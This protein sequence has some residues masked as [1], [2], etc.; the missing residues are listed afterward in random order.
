MS[1]KPA[2]ILIVEDDAG[3]AV[4]QRRRLERAG[5]QVDTVADVDAAMA[6]LSAADTSV[7]IIDYRLGDTTGLDLQRRMK[8]AQIEV[9]VILVSGAMDDAAIVEALRAGVRDV[10]VKTADYLDYLPDAVRGVLNQAATGRIMPTHTPATCILIVED[11]PG[12]ATLERKQLERAGYS[13]AVAANATEAMAAVRGGG[14][15][16]AILDQRLPDNISGLELYERWKAEGIAVP[17]ILV[18]GFADQATAIQAIR[19]GIRD[20]VPKSAEFLDYLGR[21]VD[22]VVTQERT[23]RKLAESE[24][25]LASIIGTAMDVIVMC[26]ADGKIVLFNR[27][28]QE[29]FGCSPSD[30]LGR[31]ITGFI[32]GLDLAHHLRGR[33]ELLATRQ[34]SQDP[35]AIEVSVTDIVIHD[36]SLF[37]VIPRDITER[38]NA[39][40]QLR[41]AA[42]RKDEFLGMLAHE[43]RNPLAAIMTA[44]EVLHRTQP[45]EGMAQQ[46]TGVVRR[47]SRALSRMVDDLLDVSR[48]TLGKIQLTSEPLILGEVVARAAESVRDA[49]A[50]GG[51]EVELR[52]SPEPVWLDADA[53]RLEQVVTNLLTN[54]I[55]FTPR[56]GTVTLVVAVEGADAV[57]KVSDTG[58]G[59]PADLLPRVFDLFVQG[60]ASLDR[61]RSGLGIG[62][63]LVRKIVSM[64]GGS[65]EA[66]SD[67]PGLGSTFTLRFPIGDLDHVSSAPAGG[68]YA[69]P[70]SPLRVVVVDDQQ[71]VANSMAVLISTLR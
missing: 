37:T 22:R 18:T 30:A 5:F 53:T 59:I 63:A 41:D 4:L 33:H 51:V 16:L 11:D 49:A 67:G 35:V 36:Q 39:E 6:R 46:L 61:S 58:V 52:S 9:P 62:L 64:H 50:V 21:A 20:F 43:L 28:A 48:V 3:I 26:D 56:G 65:V 47:Q 66:A 40:A 68:Q 10:V 1:T 32:A 29:L 42:R 8:A 44:G 12:T 24:L 60:D 45:A 19:L 27:S 38:R 15:S 54:A 70:G 55:K 2:T 7:V 23:E 13:V 34:S 17:A 25:R 71:D 57:L 14:I 31:P 69:M